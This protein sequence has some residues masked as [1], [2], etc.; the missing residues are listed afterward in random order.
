MQF[1]H[2]YQRLPGTFEVHSSGFGS[3]SNSVLGSIAYF[4]DIEVETKQF[5]VIGPHLK[6]SQD[7]QEG[8]IIG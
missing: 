5:L 7:H 8:T 3:V 4:Y 2:S 6:Q 1:K